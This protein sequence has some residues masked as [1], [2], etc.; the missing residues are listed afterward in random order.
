MAMHASNTNTLEDGAGRS[1]IQSHPY[2]HKEYQA[3]LG[4]TRPY[5]QHQIKSNK[6]N[7]I[8][9]SLC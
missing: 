7:K 6:L 3:S 9:G 8:N 5:P 2:L 1:Q 4:N